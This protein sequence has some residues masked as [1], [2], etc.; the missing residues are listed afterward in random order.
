MK[1]L[2][3]IRHAQSEANLQNILASRQDFPLS[4]QGK[5]DADSITAEF[6]NIAKLDRV[7]C[8]PL[9]RA[10]QTAQPIANAFG[11]QVETDDRIIE[12]ELGIYAGL[13]YADLDDCPNYMHD[14]TQRWQWIPEGGGE[15]YE[16]IT[17]RLTPFFEALE[18]SVESSILCV[19]HAVTMRMIKAILEQTLPA[20]PSAIAKN[21]EIWKVKF[22]KTG[23]AHSFE[24]IFLAGC[25][26]ANS[27]A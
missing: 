20:Y 24:S 8:S 23:N 9:L 7:I 10:Q 4:A 19:T 14:R 2:Y 21:G 26:D 1:T 15:S 17:Q 13:S 5:Q 22:T 3:F 27:R 12:Q 6:K 25:D 16:M 18:T 11:L